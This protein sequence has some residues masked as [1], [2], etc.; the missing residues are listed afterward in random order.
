M[1]RPGKAN[2]PLLTKRAV[3]VTADCFLFAACCV[4]QDVTRAV[5]LNALARQQFLVRTAEVTNRAVIF[6]FDHAV[7]QPVHELAVV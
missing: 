7:R 2:G 5:S 1:I 4:T 6:H 3:C